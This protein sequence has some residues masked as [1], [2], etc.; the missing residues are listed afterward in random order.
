MK[1]IT[2]FILCSVFIAAAAPAQPA[3]PDTLWTK[4]FGG[5]GNDF[6]HGIAGTNDGGYIITGLTESYGAGVADVYLLKTDSGGDTIWTQTYGGVQTDW[7]MGVFQTE[8][9]GYIIAGSTTSFGMGDWDAYLIK[10]DSAG[11]EEWS[12]TFG[13]MLIDAGNCLGQTT[14]GGYI[15]AGT[16]YSFGAGD[17]DLYLVKT[18]SAGNL[19]WGHT[20]GGTEMDGAAG[21]QPT[22]DG[23]Y[24]MAGWSGPG[25][26]YDAILVKCDSAGT[27]EWLQ[28]Y[29]GD[30]WDDAWAVLQTAEGGYLITGIT[31]SFGPGPVNI[32]LVKTD[33]NGNELWHRTAGEF[34]ESRGHDLKPAAGGGYIIAGSTGTMSNLQ[35]VFVFKI[36]E[37]GDEIWSVTTG[38]S[39]D[40]EAYG[41]VQTAGGG[42]VI[43]GF[44]SSFGQGDSDV[45]L[46]C[47][48]EE[49]AEITGGGCEAPVVF[50]LGQLYPNPFNSQ[51]TIP[52]TL[53]R[54]GKVELTV[55][56]VL[57]REVQSLVTGHLS[58]GKH[59]AVWDAGGC[60]SGV[61]FIQ[62]T[63]NRGQGTVKSG[64]QMEKVILVK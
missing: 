49:G 64:K 62:L 58:L 2:L 22:S 61:Y 35:D 30:D 34:G 9:G 52:F 19:I 56:D 47:L 57:G 48:D 12:R 16:T 5:G 40:E 4:H 38:A 50:G 1:N 14:D 37:N 24:I 6:A 32:Y 46:V 41:I 17:S 55:Y 39:G 28:T 43:A 20:F 53:D 63:V 13:G 25:D 36:N 42:Y 23:G 33:E 26:N 60:G 8:D 31:Y 18:D 54:A 51:T 59:E 10:T 27:Q 21:V 15:I 11:N 3:A 7:G 29:G 44:S 45:Y